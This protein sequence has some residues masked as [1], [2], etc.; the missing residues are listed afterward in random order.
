MIDVVQ[1]VVSR[2]PYSRKL[3]TCGSIRLHCT[4]KNVGKKGHIKKMVKIWQYPILKRGIQQHYF[5]SK[6]KSV[7]IRRW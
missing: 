2:A 6:T 1:E 7:H 5:F 3:R 4:K